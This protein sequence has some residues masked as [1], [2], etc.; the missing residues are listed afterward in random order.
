MTGLERVS[1]DEFP[2]AA[3]RRPTELSLALVAGETVFLPGVGPN[4]NVVK[5][6]RNP[7]G[8]VGRRGLRVETASGERGGVKGLF[9][10]AV[11]R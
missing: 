6:T 3:G 9:V 4:D 11:P 8:Y 7:Q 1:P 10:R 2:S 5:T